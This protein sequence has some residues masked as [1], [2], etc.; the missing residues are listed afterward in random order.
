MKQA[1]KLRLT[2]RTRDAVA[3]IGVG[4]P[5]IRER[6]EK[7]AAKYSPTNAEQ[8]RTLAEL[9]W[10]LISADCGDDALAVLDALCEVDGDYYWMFHALGSAFATRAWLHANRNCPTDSRNDARTALRWMHREPNSKAIT[11]SEA[12]GAL[13]RF[14]GWL[15]RAADEKGAVTALHVVS[16]AMRVLVIYQQAAK[17]GDPAAT[18]VPARQYTTRLES[19]VREARRRIESL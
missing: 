17:A 19:G 15:A 7:A 2:A 11:E 6:V 14:D 16:H 18:T 3:K 5:K 13:K 9:V 4:N 1:E 12:R 10:W 8:Y